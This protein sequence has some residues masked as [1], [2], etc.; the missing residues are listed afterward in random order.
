MPEIHADQAAL[1]IQEDPDAE[2]EPLTCT[3]I[4]GDV[5]IP[6]RDRTITYC[7][8]ALSGAYTATGFLR[9]EPG[10]VTLTLRR[11]LDNVVNYLLELDC[12]STFR[13]N[14]MCEG[15]PRWLVTNYLLA[16][17]KFNGEFTGRT[18]T[19]GGSLGPDGN[20][21]IET[22]GAI[23]ALSAQLLYQLQSERQTLTQT[24]DVND[25]DMLIR[26]CGSACTLYRARCREGYAV[27]TTDYAGV[28]GDTVL[29][30]VNSGG[31]WLP[32]ATAPFVALGRDATSVRT[33]VHSTGH[34]VIVSGGAVPGLPPEISYSDN[35]I[36]PAGQVW[37]NVN[38]ELAGSAG[39]G[40]NKLAWDKRLRLWAAADDGRI[41]VSN[42]IGTSW[43][44]SKGGVAPLNDLND[45][46]FY[47][48]LVGYAVGDSG[49]CLKTSDGAT[50][51]V[52]PGVGLPAAANF[53]GVAVNR[54]G[55]VFI[56]TNDARVFRSLDA[57]ETFA[58]LVDL[59]S[60]SIDFIEFDPQNE[61]VGVFGWNGASGGGLVYRSEDGGA[62]W[63][64]GEIGLETPANV[65]LNDMAYCDANSFFVG[66]DATGGTSWI[67]RWTRR[68][69]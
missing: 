29:Y 59:V 11:P 1:F 7:P 42:N 12:P 28:Y 17:L 19:P 22:T 38:P 45:I 10:P 30:T 31:N 66:G 68:S 62:T 20:A 5:T 13:T 27:L 36:V 39:R 4:D 9:G 34:R 63:I 33:I 51:A 58:E 32:T 56:T 21:R 60:G 49:V 15:T 44:V 47:S 37:Y 2:V 54:F 24:Q 57:G 48:D 3:G 53:L 23:S 8:S 67:G 18:I 46:W 55:H 25:I 40:V 69:S 43:A 64:R 26:S 50:W 52:V 6:E 35:A 61:Y 41:Y 16:L 65:L 14:W